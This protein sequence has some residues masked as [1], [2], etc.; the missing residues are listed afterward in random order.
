MKRGIRLRN[1]SY[2][3]YISINGI[4][5]KQKENKKNKKRKT[6]KRKMKE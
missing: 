6:K 3:I 4:F 1:D 5:K 2:L